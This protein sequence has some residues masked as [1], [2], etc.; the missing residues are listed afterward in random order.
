MRSREQLIM[1]TAHKKTANDPL[2]S[3]G[4]MGLML[5]DPAVPLTSDP[6]PPGRGPKDQIARSAVLVAGLT[7]GSMAGAAVGEAVAR[8]PYGSTFKKSPWMAA[9]IPAAGALAGVTAAAFRAAADIERRE[10]LQEL[11]PKTSPQVYPHGFDPNR[12]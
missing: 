3:F 4:E 6:L 7:L 12:Q 2:S 9:A 8:G 11:S 1:A 10:Q 5:A